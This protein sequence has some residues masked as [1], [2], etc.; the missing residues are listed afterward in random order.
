MIK[1]VVLRSGIDT[2]ARW[3]FSH[4]KGWILGY[5]FYVTSILVLLS[6][7]YRQVLLRLMY[8]IIQYILQ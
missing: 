1:A 8:K 6:Y 2:D 3:G 5:K 4:R 7:H